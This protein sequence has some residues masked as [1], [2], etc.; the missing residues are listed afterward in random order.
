MD[1]FLSQ[2]HSGDESLN[3]SIASEVGFPTKLRTRFLCFDLHLADTPVNEGGKPLP[4][5]SRYVLR[6][7]GVALDSPPESG[8]AWNPLTPIPDFEENI[9]YLVPSEIWLQP[10]RIY[11]FSA[12]SPIIGQM[13]WNLAEGILLSLIGLENPHTERELKQAWRGLKLMKQTITKAGRRV[14]STTIQRIE[15]ILD[16][17]EDYQERFG[18]NPSQE[19]LA[20]HMGFSDP[21]TLKRYLA[22][23]RRHIQ[24]PPRRSSDVA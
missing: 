13:T 11:M 16:S 1:T 4:S 23:N 21:S 6:F 3:A 14:G 8:P 15:E 18:T 10:Y 17:Y 12:G 7:C 19:E 20:T 5:D 24:W 2:F 22:N 9:L